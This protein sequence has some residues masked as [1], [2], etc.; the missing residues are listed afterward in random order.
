MSCSFDTPIILILPQISELS[1]QFIPYLVSLLSINTFPLF[2]SGIP[3]FFLPGKLNCGHWTWNNLR[4]SLSSITQ[5]CV[6]SCMHLFIH[7]FISICWVSTMYQ[8]WCW[9]LGIQLKT[10]Y[11]ESLLFWSSV[12]NFTSLSLSSLTY[13]IK[14]TSILEVYHKDTMVLRKCFTNPDL[15]ELRGIEY[16]KVKQVHMP[17]TYWY[18]IRAQ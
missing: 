12:K 7:S 17:N 4:L 16:Y 6:S 10:V 5:L 11:R 18:I 9:V 15:S 1:V 14:T 3:L 2:W 13:K 8:I